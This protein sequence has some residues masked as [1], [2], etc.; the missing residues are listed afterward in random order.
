[1]FK[2]VSLCCGH[3]GSK[4]C[5]DKWLKSAPQPTC[6]ECKVA[7]ADPRALTPSVNFALHNITRDLT[8][9]CVSRGCVWSGLYLEAEKHYN[10]CPKLPIKCQ[11]KTAN[12]VQTHYEICEAQDPMSRL[13]RESLENHGNFAVPTCRDSMRMPSR[14]WD[15]ITMVSCFIVKCQFPAS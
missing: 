13:L 1:M 2:P 14:M 3:L 5:M 4:S 10:Q 6:P 11:T 12:T 8:V 15:N 9:Q 7:V